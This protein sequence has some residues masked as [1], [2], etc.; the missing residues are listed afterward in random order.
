MGRIIKNKTV[1][2]GP[3]GAW[4]ALY[5]K[6]LDA[7]SAWEYG[8][9]E[10]QSEKKDISKFMSPPPPPP[11]DIKVKGHFFLAVEFRKTVFYSS[12]FFY[13]ETSHLLL[14]GETEFV[15]H[16]KRIAFLWPPRIVM[17]CGA[18]GNFSSYLLG[19][20]WNET[21]P[22]PPSAVGS[23]KVCGNSK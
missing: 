20:N 12:F 6:V 14:K 7:A 4:D 11:R 9:K 2:Y 19:S 18:D 21:R 3:G 22:D 1:F 16:L 17:R 15:L 5:G 8:R 10:R 23:H 13:F